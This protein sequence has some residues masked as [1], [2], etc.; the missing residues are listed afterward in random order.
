MKDKVIGICSVVLIFSLFGLCNEV[1]S[2]VSGECFNR[3]QI[4]RMQKTSLEDISG[5]LRSE[6]WIFDGAQNN[7]SFQY[8]GYNLDYDLVRWRSGSRHRG[9]NIL[10]YNRS[11]K[12]NIVIFQS[13]ENCF[14]QLIREFGDEGTGSAV[15]QQDFLLTTYREGPISV[16]F[17]EYKNDYSSRQYSI[18]VYDSSSLNREIAK[19][20][21]EEEKFQEIIARANGHFTRKEFQKAKTAYQEALVMRENPEIVE[22]IKQCDI[23]ICNEIENE[24]DR[25]SMGGDY[26]HA[27]RRYNEALRCSNNS[28]RINQKIVNARKKQT[29]AEAAQKN[30]QADIEFNSNNLEAAL[31][32]YQEV[33]RVDPGNLRAIQRI[34]EINRIIQIKEQRRTTTFSYREIN[35]QEFDNFQRAVVSGLNNLFPN[36][37]GNFIFSYVI[38]FDTLGNNLSSYKINTV[39]NRSLERLFHEVGTVRL[40]PTSVAGFKVASKE[41]ININLIWTSYPVNYRVKILSS[42]T[43]D[44]H[45]LPPDLFTGFIAR[46]SFKYGEFHFNVTEKR[47][48]NRVFS[49]VNLVKHSTKADPTSAFLSMIMPG[50]GT[51]RV[52]YGEKGGKTMGNFLLFSAIAVGSELYSRDL[53][54]Q[55]LEELD[56]ERQEGF[57]SNSDLFHYAALASAG[58]SASIY[59]YDVIWVFAKGVQNKKE[60]R[61]LRRQ[62]RSGPISVQNQPLVFP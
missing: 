50:W 20:V 30:I 19:Q 52:T 51:R 21:Q 36:E 46:Q 59:L 56:P 49:D 15:V 48:N 44:S 54:K 61:A 31:A 8:F 53:H 37:A 40:S 38:A 47:L 10:L 14:Q 45:R 29:E 43:N 7:Q 58:I 3:T 57:Q 60:S 55:S 33:S 13:S 26:Q 32:I 2:Q 41:E 1:Y 35:R 16:E 24:G 6:G 23:E 18:I 17:R 11:G 9:G 22:R 62:L 25:L 27:I 39:S 28:S 34:T 12:P 4:L 42:Q 5:F